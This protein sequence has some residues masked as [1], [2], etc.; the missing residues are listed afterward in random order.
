MTT[1]FYAPIEIQDALLK[2]GL[3]LNVLMQNNSQERCEK[4]V[5]LASETFIKYMENED[6]AKECYEKV[7]VLVHSKN[8]YYAFLLFDQMLKNNKFAFKAAK[9]DG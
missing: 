1:T 6:F 3:Y 8:N 4:T 5:H 7:K 9:K 2:F